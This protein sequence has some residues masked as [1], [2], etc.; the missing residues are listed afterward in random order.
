MQNDF[1]NHFFKIHMNSISTD[2]FDRTDS[3][4]SFDSMFPSRPMWIVIFLIC[5]SYNIKIY[6]SPICVHSRTILKSN[7]Q[8]KG[9]V[10]YHLLGKPL[11]YLK[12]LSNDWWMQ[13]FSWQ[14]WHFYLQELQIFSMRLQTLSDS[15]FIPKEVQQCLWGICSYASALVFVEGW[16]LI[17]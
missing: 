13:L 11:S 7:C 9:E 12:K 16:V 1:K 5:L 15:L 10:F 8:K 4:H 17:Y 6:L 14:I 2:N 3:V